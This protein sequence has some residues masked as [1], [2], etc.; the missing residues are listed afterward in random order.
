METMVVGLMGRKRSGKDTVGRFLVEDFGFKRLSFADALRDVALDLNPIVDVRHE[1]DDQWTLREVVDEYG[2]EGAKDE[3]AEVR[4]I[5]QDLGVAIRHVN[6]DFWVDIVLRQI[7]PGQRYVITDVR[8]PN[9]FRAVA[10][11][12]PNHPHV[13]VVL[14]RVHR[15]GLDQSDTHESET[16][17]DN[18]VPNWIIDND[19]DLF[20]LRAKV[21]AMV[22][23]TH[24]G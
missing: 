24:G 15:P 22:E 23:S 4:R 18:Y 2:W 20:Q 19:S 21:R 7:L 5:L 16:A 12:F 17:L 8:F 14:C 6:Q 1:E 11:C 10:D 9:E 13:P 3:I